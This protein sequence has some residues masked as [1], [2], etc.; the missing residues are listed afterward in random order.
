MKQKISERISEGIHAYRDGETLLFLEE[1]FESADI[2]KVIDKKHIGV[3]VT[4]AIAKRR[5]KLSHSLNKVLKI[6][7]TLAYDSETNVDY[8]E[9]IRVKA[10]SLEE[11]AI[12][13]EVI[14]I[15]EKRST[16]IHE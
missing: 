12:A 16:W 11:H 13:V 15:Q 5:A 2:S 3:R 4:F 9:V 7:E 10:D 8:F 6:L 1:P 14:E